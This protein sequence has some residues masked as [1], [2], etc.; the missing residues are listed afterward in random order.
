MEWTST[1]FLAP[2]R[3][4]KPQYL[5]KF[6]PSTPLDY[7]NYH[8]KHS[9]PASIQQS[10]QQL[11]PCHD[12]F[13]ICHRFHTT[14]IP[15]TSHHTIVNPPHGKIPFCGLRPTPPL[16]PTPYLAFYQLTPPPSSPSPSRETP[17]SP[18]F[19]PNHQP[20]LQ[21]SPPVPVD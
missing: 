14:T 4:R 5:Y 7:D 8:S 11:H 13:L 20:P 9:S 19:T 6:C 15:S 2:N 3:P 12:A 1:S 17:S 18:I 10:S 16:P 21:R